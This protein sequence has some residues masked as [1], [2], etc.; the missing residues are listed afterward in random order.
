MALKV[1]DPDQV[2]VMFAGLPIRG[3]AD[4]T[5]VTIEQVSEAFTEVV[6]SDGEVTRTKNNDRRC[7]IKFTLMQS[8]D[9]NDVLSAIHNL[10]LEAPNGVGVAPLAIKD[11]SGRFQFVAPEAWV[12]KAPNAE[13][14]KEAGPREWELCCND[15]KRFD[16]GN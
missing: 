5:F 16:G 8:S 4:G 10:D 11:M 6:G 3:Y 15:P 13:F 7:S 2:V 14:G 12:K 9:S 1:Y